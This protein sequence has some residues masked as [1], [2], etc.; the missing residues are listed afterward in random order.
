MW[1][2]WILLGLI[3]LVLVLSFVLYVIVFYARPRPGNSLDLTGKHMP[4]ERLEGV[5]ALIRA[6]EA[7]PYERVYI[8]SFDGLRL[9]ARYYHVS[10]GAP[11]DILCHGYRSIAQQDFC[12]GF[13]LLREI[14]HNLLL[15]DQ[16]AHGYSQGHTITFGLREARDCVSWTEY[17]IARC[18]PEARVFLYGISMGASTVLMASGLDLPEQ[19]KAIVADCGFS[20]PAAVIQDVCR[21]RRLPVKLT[22]PFIKLGARLFGRFDLE[23]DSAVQAVARSHTP[24]LIIHGEADRFVPF[25]MCREIYAACAAPKEILTV[26]GAGHGQSYLVD[27]PAYTRTVLDFLAR[28]GGADAVRRNSEEAPQADDPATAH[29]S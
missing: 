9:A 4:Q 8:T 1:L 2:L 26:P 7:V 28:Y 23:A 6:L 29:R 3:A 13:S 5:A 19:V 12:G 27:K 14:G 10:D 24:T 16:R 18:G 25:P 17:A 20:S 15:I 21:A 22:Y 11:V